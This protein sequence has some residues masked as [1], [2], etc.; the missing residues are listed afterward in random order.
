MFL[1]VKMLNRPLIAT[2]IYLSRDVHYIKQ[3]SSELGTSLE[4][5]NNQ[6]DIMYKCLKKTFR[7]NPE[8]KALLLKSTDL[9]LVGA[10]PNRL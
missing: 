9:A 6:F 2:K 8:L 7:Q 4:W 3:L 5:E 1:K 10:T